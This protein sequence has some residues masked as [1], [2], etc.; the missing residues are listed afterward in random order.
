MV[1]LW[2]LE[3]LFTTPTPISQN[4]Q[5]WRNLIRRVTSVQGLESLPY[6]MC[7]ARVQ[8]WK[9]VY[10]TQ[11]VVCG[12]RDRNIY[13]TG[14]V[15]ITQFVVWWCRCRNI[16]LAEY[17]CV[18]CWNGIFYVSQLYCVEIYCMTVYLIQWVCG[19]KG[20]G[21]F[22]NWTWCMWRQACESLRHWMYC[23]GQFTLLNALCED[24]GLG[25]FILL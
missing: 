7:C 16:Y 12:Y 15:H 11:C 4:R 20:M 18:G 25:K 23:V 8:C 17:V 13:I 2:Q 24:A 3:N 9:Q 5:K 19:G 14:Q 1:L 21:Q 22:I 6:S 10:L